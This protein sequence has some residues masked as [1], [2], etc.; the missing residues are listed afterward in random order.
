MDL[1]TDWTIAQALPCWSG[2]SVLK[3]LQYIM[4]TYGKPLRIL[5]DNGEEFMS[6]RVQGMLQRFGIRHD[7]TTPYHPQTNGRLEKF[8]DVLTQMLARM[9]TPQR[10]TSWDQ[11]LPDALL[12]HRAHTSS[13]TGVSPFFLMYGR[14]ACLPSQRSCEATEQNPTDK[15][16]ERLQ[17]RQLEH[18][19]NLARF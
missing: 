9:T 13:S 5:T 17:E 1:S 8:N 14:E 19:Q 4:Y 15:E 10:Q 11:A 3:M 7:H 18:V 2:Q 6:Y 12:A 16:V